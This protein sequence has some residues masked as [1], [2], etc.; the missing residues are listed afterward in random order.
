ME[1]VIVQDFNTDEVL[2]TE[3]GTYDTS[4]NFTLDDAQ[5]STNFNVGTG[6]WFGMLFATIG[7]IIA[8]GWKIFTKAKLPG[9]GTLV[10]IYNVYLW[11]K[12]VGH[13][14]WIWWLLFLH[15]APIVIIFVNFEIAK[16]FGKGTR[17]ALGLL[18]LPIVF[19]PILAWGD[20]QY[21]EEVSEEQ[22]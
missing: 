22:K 13:P 12:L 11:F 1:E 6:V 10:P 14:I 5:L 3:L 15:V 8:S 20:A 2:T 7:V 4:V 9:W 18:F 19:Y 16:K 17:F 21:Q